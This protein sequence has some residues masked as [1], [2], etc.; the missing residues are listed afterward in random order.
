MNDIMAFNEGKC[1]CSI[2]NTF[3]SVFSDKQFIVRCVM[4][5]HKIWMPY[6]FMSIITL[7]LPA[8]AESLIVPW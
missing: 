2:T 7:T 8:L 6:F 1:Y 3:Q 5:V 4:L